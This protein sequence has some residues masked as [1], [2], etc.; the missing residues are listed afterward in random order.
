MDHFFVQYYIIKMG[1]ILSSCTINLVIKKSFYKVLFMTENFYQISIL[2]YGTIVNMMIFAVLVFNIQIIKRAIFGEILRENEMFCSLFELW[3]FARFLLFL[4][5][6]IRNEYSIYCYVF[7]M[8]LIPVF[9][10]IFNLFII[11]SLQN[12]DVSFAH[13]FIC[14]IY[15]QIM[16]KLTLVI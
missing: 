8:A 12:S 6:F 2:I 11:C 7:I 1:I 15:I 3:M 4:Q 10:H 5:H 14:H 16:Y 13:L 9:Y